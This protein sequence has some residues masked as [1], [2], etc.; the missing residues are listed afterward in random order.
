[1]VLWPEL[2]EFSSV[3]VLAAGGVGSG[4]Q[5]AAALALGAAG[6]WCGT[7]WL[8]S[9][10]DHWTNRVEK[11]ILYETEAINAVQSRHRTGKPARMNKSVLTEAWE[12]KEALMMP[13]QGMLYSETQLRLERSTADPD[14]CVGKELVSIFCGQNVCRVK[15]PRHCEDIVVDMVE[16]CKATIERLGKLIVD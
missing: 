5:L 11:E 9:Y 4:K 2:T 7:A 8:G 15:G 16:E 13:V 6:G 14:N 3:P 1:M 10:E 12:K